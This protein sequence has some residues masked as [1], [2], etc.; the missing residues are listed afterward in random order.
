MKRI[1]MLLFGFI[2]VAG[3]AGIASAQSSD[4]TSGTA[5]GGQAEVR[6]NATATPNPALEAVREK[7]KKFAAKERQTVEK[8]IATMAK[9]VEAEATSKGDGG[10]TVAGRIAAEFGMS[11][12][13]IVAERNQFGRG[14]GELM[15]AHTL[16]ANAKTTLTVAD[17][18][19][20]RSEGM[21]W[22]QIAHGLDL[23]MGDVVAAVKAESKVATGRAKAD[24]KPAM[25]RGVNA[26][27]GAG[28]QAGAK[29][30]HGKDGVTPASV[31][32]GVG[33]K[34]GK[35]QGGGK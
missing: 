9:E 5:T 17:V 7:A 26:G 35:E 10:V 11:A 13:A 4:Q 28:A 24:G 25:I 2:L 22:G 29:I 32:V 34:V 20:L 1:A 27:V 12:D 8:Q 21:G 33:A 16:A 18:F 23:K 15:I 3:Q 19:Q 30:G 6:S 14:W 31:G